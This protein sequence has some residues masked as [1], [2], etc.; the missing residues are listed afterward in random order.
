MPVV[1]C[2]LSS[3]AAFNWLHIL[4]AHGRGLILGESLNLNHIL[5]NKFLNPRFENAVLLGIIGITIFN[6]WGFNE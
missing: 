5:L 3:N 4:S 6:E 2:Y 1:L